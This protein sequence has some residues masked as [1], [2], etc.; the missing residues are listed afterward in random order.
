MTKNKIDRTQAHKDFDV[1]MGK[2]LRKTRLAESYINPLT[3]RTIITTQSKLAKKLGVSF[4]QV[5]K[6][7]KGL[8]VIGLFKFKQMCV[9]FNK[10]PKDVFESVDVEM[11]NQKQHPIIEI[12][13]E[14]NVE[15]D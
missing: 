14:Q 2:W 1:Q 11:W 12:N 15:K 5:Q 7:E 4:Q 6:Y 13:K 3:K 10:C 9:F 8:N